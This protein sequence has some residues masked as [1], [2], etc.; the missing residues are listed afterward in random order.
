MPLDAKGHFIFI[1]L[2][3]IIYIVNERRGIYMVAPSFQSLT[4][5]S[6]K[7]YVGKTGKLYVKVLTKNGAEREGT[8][9]FRNG[10]CQVLLKRI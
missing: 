4:M 8:L 1:F 6:K 2:Y 7:P 9:V 10:I 3:V 5:V